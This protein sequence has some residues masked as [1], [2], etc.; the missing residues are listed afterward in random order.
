MPVLP[1]NALLGFFAI[2]LCVLADRR[3]LLTQVGS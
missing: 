2:G 1:T 3:G